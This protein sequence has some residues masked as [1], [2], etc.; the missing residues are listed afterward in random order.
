MADEV[1]KWI[2]AGVSVGIDNG[3]P[4]LSKTVSQDIGGTITPVS[5]ALRDDALSSSRVASDVPVGVGSGLTY[6]PRWNITESDNSQLTMARI[7]ARQ[8]QDLDRIGWR[9]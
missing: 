3:M 9:Q 5:S 2:P 4:D 1:G 6:S 8:R 7:D